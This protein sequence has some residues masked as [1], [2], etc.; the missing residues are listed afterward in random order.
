MTRTANIARR[1]AVIEQLLLDVIRP[2]E[3]PHI[4]IGPGWACLPWNQLVLLDS[5]RQLPM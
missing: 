3:T 5:N 4:Y 1:D 2:L